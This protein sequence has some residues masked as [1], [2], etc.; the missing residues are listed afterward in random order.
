MYNNGKH[1]E[2]KEKYKR[3]AKEFKQLTAKLKEYKDNIKKLKKKEADNNTSK[4]VIA[5]L[6]L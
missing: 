3:L 6:S 4:S 1:P 5:S 2:Y